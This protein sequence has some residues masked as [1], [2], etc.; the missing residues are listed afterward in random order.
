M[1]ALDNNKKRKTMMNALSPTQLW[2]WIDSTGIKSNSGMWARNNGKPTMSH[3]VDKLDTARLKLLKAHISDTNWS[4]Y[5]N[6]HL[7]KKRRRAVG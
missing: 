6:P 1:N 2:D 4:T 5:V 3:V 7:S